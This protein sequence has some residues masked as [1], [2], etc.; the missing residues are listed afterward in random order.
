MGQAKAEFLT[1]AFFPHALSG[2]GGVIFAVILLV[3]S[4]ALMFA[5]RSIIKGLAFLV[6]GL[7][8]SAHHEKGRGGEAGVHRDPFQ[9]R[10]RRRLA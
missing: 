2:P 5:G 1:S 6:V 4:L 10:V 3:L 8:E 7:A 9:A